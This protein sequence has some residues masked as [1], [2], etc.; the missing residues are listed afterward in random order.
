MT[1]RERLLATLRGEPVDRPA[2]NFYEINGL[3][4]TSA[5]DP[6][7]IYADPSW[8]PLIDLAAEQTDRLVMRPVPFTADG[9]PRPAGAGTFERT[10]DRDG[11]AVT[12]LTVR[13]GRRILTQRTVRNPDINTVWTTEHLLKDVDDLKAWLDLPEDRSPPGAVDVPA[14]LEVEK[15]LGD[16]G[17]VMLDTADPLCGVAPL[18]DMADYTVI[19]LTE[20]DL[21]HQALQRVARY[22]YPRI[23]AAARSLPGRLWRI[24]GPE[25]ASPPYLPPELFNEYVVEYVKPM[26]AMIQRYGGFAR[27][28]SHGRLEAILDLICATGCDALDPI[29]PPDQGDVEL[30]FVREHYGRQLVLFGNLEA[31]D[32]ENLP[33]VEFE[34]KVRKAL[35]EGPGGRGFVLMPS[36]CPY[37]RKLSARA[38]ANYEV[39]TRCVQGG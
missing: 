22:L 14:I 6:F 37:G 20:P 21:F 16:T 1:R 24:Y 3:E 29:E 11:N 25:Y 19:A 27:I 31:T 7:N 23:E 36:A 9:A 15:Q 18:F 4:N 12:V 33:T 13:T 39:M 8:K 17:L 32:L 38:L 35:Q 30:R 34:H 5:A 10:L 2:F 26:V 28:H